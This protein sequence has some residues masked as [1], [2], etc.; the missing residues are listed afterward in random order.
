[1]LRIVLLLALLASMLPAH[2]ESNPY[3][4]VEFQVEAARETANDLLVATLNAD[5]QDKQP[6]EVARLLNGALNEA[7]KVAG[8]YASVKTSSGNQRTYPVYG[9]NNQI[10]GWRGQGQIRLESRDFKAA[11]ELIMK[12]QATLQLAGVQFTVAP[13]SRALTENGLITEAI[14]AFGQRAEAVRRALGMSGYKIVRF[15]INTH[16]APGIP[17]QMMRSD[18]LMASAI[19]APEFTGGESRL[20]VEINGTIELQ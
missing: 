2:A 1:M 9:K 18:A 4:R 15:T 10:T 13:D 5:V 11:G 3:N 7:L 6:A 19:P 8:S 14:K 16:G 17:V 20:T 12:L